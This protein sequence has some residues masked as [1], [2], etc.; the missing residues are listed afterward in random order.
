MR[1]VTKKAKLANSRSQMC[2]HCPVKKIS[3]FCNPTFMRVC[4]DAFIEGYK[5][6]VKEA[7]KEM[8]LNLNKVK[9]DK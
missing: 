1:G 9:D 7:E 6:G 5:K 3:K 4:T 8:K 2:R